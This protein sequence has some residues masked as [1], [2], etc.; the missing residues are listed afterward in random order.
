MR[1]V[2]RIPAPE[3][4]YAIREL[5]FYLDDVSE[6]VVH[7]VLRVL[8]RTMRVG[9]RPLIAAGWERLLEEAGFQVGYTDANPIVL[10]EAK[11]FVA[12]GGFLEAP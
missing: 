10:L 12:D 2:P 8:S 5:G 6:D 1:K 3:G 4:R 7:D 11:R 9:A